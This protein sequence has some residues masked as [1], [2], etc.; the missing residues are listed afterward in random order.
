[1]GNDNGQLRRQNLASVLQ[2]VHYSRG[3][4][5]AELTRTLGL[6]R[7]TIGDLVGALSEAKWVKEVDDAPREGAGRP[8]P[9]VVPKQH[10]L[11]ASVNPEVDAVDVALVA[12]GGRVVVRRRIAVNSPTIDQAVKITARAVTEMAAE[13]APSVV[14]G[15][16]V[17]IPGIVRRSDGVVR[18][19]P[20]LGW[21]ESKFAEAL[22]A[23]L[24]LPVEVANDAHLGCRAESVFG[25]G[26]GAQ[27]FV[28]LNGGASGIGG[29]LMVDGRAISGRDGYAG[30]IGHVSVDP[31][32]P[33]C[34][35]GA[36][37][38]LESLVR[39]EHLLKALGLIE[40]DDSELEKAL[41]V[42]KE[43]AVTALVELQWSWLRTALRGLV[44]MLNPEKIVLG[45]HLAIL[46]EALSEADRR[47]AFEG[48][49]EAS[50]SAV[51]VEVAALGADRLILGA[52][53]LAW[54]KPLANPLAQ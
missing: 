33:E 23:A 42:S 16:G 52:A 54:D 26:V 11:V 39:R 46:W 21:R 38:C 7:S 2:L 19:A 18:L 41:R 43:P 1:M 31:N 47:S 32:G 15:A 12:L 6:N 22:S 8:S 30:E 14:V 51:L 20:H 36:T 34:A 13:H 24:S 48:A 44:N 25:A 35:C 17:A 45:G 50:A 28:Y 5:R 37:G 4:T 10:W 40:V 53:E 49:L 9:R 3:V 29:G 27:N